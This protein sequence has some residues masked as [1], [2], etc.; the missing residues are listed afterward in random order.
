MA[1]IH[2]GT[3]HKCGEQH[4]RTRWSN[5]IVEEART[6][7]DDGVGSYLT[8]AR[9]LSAKYGKKLS[10]DTVRDWCEYRTRIAA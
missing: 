7:D 5:E 9:K 8:I 2:P 10:E 3:G 4:H 6:M 1:A